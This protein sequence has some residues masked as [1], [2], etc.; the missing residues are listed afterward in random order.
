MRD[1]KS[2]VFVAKGHFNLLSTLVHLNVF[3]ESNRSN[4]LENNSDDVSAI[5]NKIL[6]ETLLLP[7]LFKLDPRY[8]ADVKIEADDYHEDTALDENY[9]KPW[10][11]HILLHSSFYTTTYH[12]QDYEAAVMICREKFKDE[13]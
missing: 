7:R 8:F 11:N 13:K 1:K 10:Q 9:L 2:N 12:G 3:I 6:N 5:A 4:G